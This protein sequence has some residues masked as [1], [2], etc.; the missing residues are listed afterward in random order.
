M[1]FL[2][3]CIAACLTP[4]FCAAQLSTAQ[5]SALQQNQHVKQLHSDVRISI[6]QASILQKELNA[7]WHLDRIDQPN[8][9]LNGVYDYTLDGSGVNVYVLDTVS[10]RLWVSTSDCLSLID[11]ALSPS[12]GLGTGCQKRPRGV[13]VLCRQQSQGPLRSG[14]SV[15]L[16]CCQLLYE[17]FQQ[18]VSCKSLRLCAWPACA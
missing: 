17:A 7:P 6:Q 15:N 10:G 14:R 1:R 2:I 4:T 16:T 9:P 18:L 5:Q 13:P 12:W 3:E 11:F 8:L